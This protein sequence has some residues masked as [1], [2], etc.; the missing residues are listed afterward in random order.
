M[1]LFW[2]IFLSFWLAA[3]LIAGSFFFLGR[4]SSSA[5]IDR[6]LEKL[7]TQAEIVAELWRNEGG[8]PAVMAWLARQ[9][10]EQGIGLMTVDGH[11][12]FDHGRI[13]RMH[14]RWR[15]I[16]PVKPGVNVLPD[17]RILLATPLPGIQPPLMLV[18]RLHPRQLHDI[19]MPL[20]LLLAAGIIA[21]VSGVLAGILVRRIRRL[22]EAV[23]IISQ[24][25]LSA[26]A[27]LN[28]N[29]EVSALARDFN[30]M[31]ERIDQ[32]MASQRQ[33]VSD[34]S[35]ELR[36]PLARLR[37][38]LEL[39]QRSSNPTSMLHKIGKE[40][41]ELEQ[42]VT[43][44]LSLARM[45]SGQA[46][47]DRQAIDL[48]PLLEKIA[49]D[50]NFEGATEDRQVQLQHCDPVKI[51]IDPVLMHA[52]IENVVRNALRYS[53]PGKPV[54]I[55]SELRPGQLLIHIEDQGP[56]VPEQDLQ[57]LFEP[58]TRVAEARDRDSGGF[59]LGLAMTGK[60]LEAHGGSAQAVN[61]TPTGLHVTLTLPLNSNRD[62][63]TA[64]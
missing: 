44:L 10:R 20:M 47:L 51:H 61:A 49:E 63:K 22:R 24:G 64:P 50:A 25:D 6:N 45:E 48:C 33:L 60:I 37:I 43:Q 55:Q 53:P 5:V 18:R 21:L 17:G 27:E 52:A 26:R 2:R 14:G 57:R 38:A 62:D 59:G 32:M 12:P 46:S 7:K 36:S 39:A 30:H 56:G 9:P 23:N 29:D 1:S 54:I 35:H 11:P 4:S 31:A 16:G 41:D 34:V 13:G 19:P 58:F 15:G 3:A 42:M 8:Q 28:G 40:A